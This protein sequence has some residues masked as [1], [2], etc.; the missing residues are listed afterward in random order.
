V[1]EKEYII[2][3]SRDARKRHY[4]KTFRGKVV[5]FMVQ[6]EIRHEDNWKEVVR[7]D[8]AHGYAHCDS[9]SMT[10]KMEKDKLYFRFED[11]LTLSDDIDDNWENYKERFLAGGMP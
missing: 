1:A 3:Y 5:E 7:Y 9:Y 4:H 8:C 6:L 2:P 11:A 10:G